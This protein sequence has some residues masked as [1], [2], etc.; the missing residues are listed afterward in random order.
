MSNSVAFAHAYESAAGL[1]PTGD[2]ARARTVLVELER[3]Y[4]H[5]N[6]IGAACAGVGF[7]LGT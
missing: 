5:L 7:A 1:W 2:L 4:N 3:L 6:D